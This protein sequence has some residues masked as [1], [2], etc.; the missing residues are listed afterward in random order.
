MNSFTK[1]SRFAMSSMVLLLAAALTGC[2]DRDPILGIGNGVVTTAVVNDVSVLSSNPTA[3]AT[4]VCPDATIDVTFTV[5]SGLGMDPL[6]V[7]NT[8]FTLVGPGP[9]FTP[10]VATSITMDIPGLI[11]TFTPSTPLVDGDLY[12]I[13]IVSG[14]SGAVDLDTPAN[15][16]LANFTSTF[17]AGPQSG[18]CALPPG[19]SSVNMGLAEPFGIAATAG[20][21][22]APTLPMTHINGDVVLDPDFTCNAVSVDNAGGFGLCGGSPPTINGQV[23]TNTFPNT[24]DSAAIK[25]DL[26]AAFISIT[27]PAGPPAAGGLAGGVAIAAPTTMGAP[28]VI[29]VLGDNYFT[30]G[31]YISGT[32]ILISDD[33]TLDGLGDPNAEFFFQSASTLTTAD[34]AVGPGVH[35]R[36][37]LINGAKASNVWWQVASSATIGDFT[38]FEGNILAAIDITM[39]VGATSCGRM[40]A[41]AWVGVPGGMGAFVFE[42]NVVSVPGNG[43]L[44]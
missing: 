40:M 26:N 38:E 24:T 1:N 10:V 8:T 34:G 27:P 16:L 43:C 18:V 14:A 21:T 29:M 23:I 32:S 37:L 25:A 41:G 4:L 22:N 44:L 11:A 31:V 42:S 3:A 6:T 5:P 36:I 19:P 15:E 39:K 30:P 12:T 2:S 17:T 35:T 28:G 9:L 20:V 13:T 33:L 7:N